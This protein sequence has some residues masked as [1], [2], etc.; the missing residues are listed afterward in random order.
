VP[1]NKGTPNEPASAKR[2]HRSRN[3]PNEYRWTSQ[4][5]G[6]RPDPSARCYCCYLRSCGDETYHSRETGLGT[7]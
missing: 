1:G 5:R 3:V 7:D 4:G 2:A 6:N